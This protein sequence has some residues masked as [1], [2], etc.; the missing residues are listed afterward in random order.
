MARYTKRA[1]GGRLEGNAHNQ[2][3]WGGG[4]SCPPRS[5]AGPV[6]A[7]PFVVKHVGRHGF[8]DQGLIN[9]KAVYCFVKDI[10]KRDGPWRSHVMLVP[11][12][13]H[14]RSGF[15]TRRP[16]T[17]SQGQHEASFELVSPLK[18]SQGPWGPH[19]GRTPPAELELGTPR[20]HPGQSCSP[21]TSPLGALVL[22]CK[23]LHLEAQVSS[24]QHGRRPH[25]CP[26]FPA[27]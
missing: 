26:V 7:S 15:I 11:R 16:E 12:F 22:H 14:R 5:T 1:P 3:R 19:S 8:E 17:V 10:L 4:T 2:R 9:F 21:L 13:R 23:G 24:S 25:A 18:R 6:P 20:R 27:P